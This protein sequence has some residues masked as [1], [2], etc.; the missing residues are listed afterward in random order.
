MSRTSTN[1]TA[2]A[3][4]TAQALWPSLLAPSDHGRPDLCA[5]SAEGVRVRFAD[6]RELLDGS[7]GLW[8]TNIGY[9]NRAIARAAAEAL[10]D[11]SYLSVFR[12][13]N[14]YARR[15]ADELVEL[16]GAEHYGRVLFSTSGGAANDLVMKLARQYHALRGEGRRKIVVGLRGGYHGLTFGGFALTGDDLGQQVYG[17]DQRLVR[18]VTPN[19]PAELVTLLARQGAQ[20]AA[21]VVEPVLGSGAVPLTDDYLATLLA[22]REEHGFLL[23]ADEVATGFCRTGDFFAT[24]RWP[25]RPDLLIASKGLTNGTSAAAAVLASRQVAGVF[26]E[27]DAVLSHGETQAGTPVTCATILATLAEMC[28]LDAVG[29]SHRLSALLDE[30]LAALAASHDLVTGSTGAGCFRSIR[31][32]TPDGQPFPQA[33]VPALV[34]AVRAAGAIVHPGVHGV[35]L[36][37]ALTYTEA[38]LDELLDCV[39]TGLDAVT[40]AALAGSAR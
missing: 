35:Q 15:A 8:N 3:V 23:V 39:R 17:V 31:L 12:Y 29:L 7:S 26:D 34:A 1:G 24:E 5:V 11:A 40:P 32:R 22:L 4:R 9:G 21:V 6:G 36:F 28:R 33:E 27:A 10:T 2:D 30:R 25:A 38:D 20:I 18:H 37:P 16:A 14:T 13:E 19:D